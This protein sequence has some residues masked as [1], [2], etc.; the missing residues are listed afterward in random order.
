[1]HS[2]RTECSIRVKKTALLEYIDLFLLNAQK[3]YAS[4]F[5]Q[6]ASIMSLIRNY[7]TTLKWRR[8]GGTMY[9]DPMERLTFCY[10]LRE[11]Y[12]RKLW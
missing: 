2:L 3:N 1:M 6:N 8:Y 12:M 11:E 10:V 9:R 5:F 4:N 7:V